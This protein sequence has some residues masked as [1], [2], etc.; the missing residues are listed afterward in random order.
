MQRVMAPRYTVDTEPTK[1]IAAAGDDPSE[2]SGPQELL[3]QGNEALEQAN[4]PRD[5]TRCLVTS[6]RRCDS[7]SLLYTGRMCNPAG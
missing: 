3:R 2:D 7:S 5:W 6:Y 1:H 4:E